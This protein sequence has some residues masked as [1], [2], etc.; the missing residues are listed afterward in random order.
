MT[1]HDVRLPLEVERG[2]TGGPGFNTTVLGLSSGFEQRNINWERSRGRWDI[3]YGLRE[4]A[5]QEAVL[6]F[7]YARQGR[8]H[9]F[10]FR[11]WT[12]YQIGDATTS[13]P[14]DIGVGD[15]T[16]TQFQIFRRYVSGTVTFSRAVTRPVSGTVRVFLDNVEQLSGF[17]VDA[18]TG[19]VTFN[20]APAL[21]VVVGVICDFDVPAR[22]DTDQLNQ[23]AFFDGNY[24]VPSIPVIEVRETLVNLT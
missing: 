24:D 6:A 18:N 23:T 15:A 1:F 9:T 5:D 13:T 2:A 4:K 3:G 8:A 22:F 14:G 7:F 21:N 11:D 20:A 19:V 12:D 16:A 10:R 17:T